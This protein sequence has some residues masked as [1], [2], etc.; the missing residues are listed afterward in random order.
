MLEVADR[1]CG[2]A[3]ILV[4]NAGIQSHQPF[5]D[6][7]A[8]QWRELMSVNLDS[9]YNCTHPFLKKALAAGWGRVISISS[10]SARRGSRQHVH[11]CTAKAGVLGFT[12]ALSLEIAQYGIT[13]NAICPGII[14]T[15][16]IEETM[17]KKRD[18]WLGEMHIKR[19]GRPEDIAGMAA[20]LVS[21]EAEW[22]TGQAF[23]VNG[24]IVTP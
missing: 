10:M 16:M 21:D 13:V 1:E 12:R 18:E 4:N 17:Q 22:I 8:R 5:L 19:F 2:T 24:G 7:D 15:E 14:E 23:D 20:F 9:L 11:Y 6:M 3:T